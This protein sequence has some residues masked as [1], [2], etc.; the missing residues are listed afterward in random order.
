MAPPILLARAM[1]R[2]LWPFILTLFSLILFRVESNNRQRREMIKQAMK[3]AAI[4]A[5]VSN[6]QSDVT[7]LCHAL[8]SL[9][10]LPDSSS[11][12]SAHVLVFHDALSQ[13]QIDYLKTCT[14]RFVRFP[15]VG[16][17]FDTYFP[18]GFDPNEEI[19]NWTKRSKWSYQQMIRFWITQIWKH[20]ALRE[21]TTLMRLDSDACWT[22]HTM[23]SRDTM[24]PTLA[25]DKFY[26][27]NIFK[28]DTM[29]QDIREFVMNYVKTH[30][31]TPK[32]PRLYQQ[33][34]EMTDDKCPSFYNNFEITRIS[35]MQQPEIVQWHE[36]WTELPPFGVFRNRWGDA[37]ERFMAMALFATPDMIQGKFTHM[38]RGYQHPCRQA[39]L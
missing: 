26:H 11:E 7:N 10:H 1:K 16:Y 22:V 30:N 23:F 12:S 14:S 15:L 3:G 37:V 21:Y 38:P 24:L 39:L 34:L 31:I 36:A 20:E 17:S 19:P 28:R 29:C 32:N 33:V 2:L 9:R 6:T 18:P 4:G 8:D 25:H 5:L 13:T 35:F 27:A